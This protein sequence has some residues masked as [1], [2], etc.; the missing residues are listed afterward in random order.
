MYGH[1]NIYNVKITNSV[2]PRS[3]CKLCSVP[4]CSTSPAKSCEIKAQV[5]LT[6]NQRS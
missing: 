1:F 3:D 6:Y 4:S 5:K 2:Y